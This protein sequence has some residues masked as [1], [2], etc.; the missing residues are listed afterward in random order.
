MATTMT[1]RYQPYLMMSTAADMGKALRPV[2]AAAPIYRCDRIINICC[3][4]SNWLPFWKK[5]H[6]N[7]E[8]SYHS[9]LRRPQHTRHDRCCVRHLRPRW[10]QHCH[11]RLLD[12]RMR[13]Y[14]QYFWLLQ[15]LV[16]L[17]AANSATTTT[18]RAT[19]RDYNDRNLPELFD[20]V[21]DT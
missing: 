9:R 21:Y 4:I 2:I 17:L 5:C 11:R 12:I 14:P 15:R 16:T 8:A 3:F 7:Y 10:V 13:S 18:K 6:Q 20:V 1:I 19:T